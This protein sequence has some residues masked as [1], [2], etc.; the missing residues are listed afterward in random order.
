MVT[1]TLKRWGLAGL[2]QTAEHGGPPYRNVP[3]RQYEACDKEGA[4]R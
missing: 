4:G 2:A 3:R 1:T